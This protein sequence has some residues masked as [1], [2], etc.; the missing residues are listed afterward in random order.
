MRCWTPYAIKQRWGVATQRGLQAGLGLGKCTEPEFMALPMLREVQEYVKPFVAAMHKLPPRKLCWQPEG[1]SLK[2]RGQMQAAPHRDAHDLGRKQIVI[3][4]SD[5]AF[6]VW[7]G[8][9]KLPY[10]D[11]DA[12]AGNFRTGETFRDFLK[13]NSCQ[14]DFACRAGDVLI[15]KG[16][17]FVDGSP[18]VGPNHPAPRVMTYAKFWPPGTPMGQRHAKGQCQCF[19]VAPAAGGSQ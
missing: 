18:P 5:G 16:G 15:F 12:P 14:L 2:G 3:A 1:A 8:S 6:S 4:L 11:A 7:P 19:G 10:W 17:V 13:R 9:H